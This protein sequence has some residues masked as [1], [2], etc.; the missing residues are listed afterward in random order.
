MK[1]PTV[2]NIRGYAKGYAKRDVHEDIKTVENKF[3]LE[4]KT[5]LL[6]YKDAFTFL[7]N[8]FIKDKNIFKSNHNNYAAGIAEIL[9]DAS[10]CQKDKNFIVP[11]ELTTPKFILDDIKGHVIIKYY[12]DEKF[13][14]KEDYLNLLG[15][16]MFFLCHKIF[17]TENVLSFD[18]NKTKDRL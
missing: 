4:C 13:V 10:H 6:E 16:Q 3:R 18:D 14:I 8:L 5:G 15:A 2:G 12:E 1:V 9:H 17:Y 7:S 11:I